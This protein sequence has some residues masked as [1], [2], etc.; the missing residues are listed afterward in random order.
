[1]RADGKR[2]TQIGS[3]GSSFNELCHDF[4]A[5]ATNA[6]SIVQLPNNNVG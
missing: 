3:F 5:L 1:M 6:A 4:L 2:K